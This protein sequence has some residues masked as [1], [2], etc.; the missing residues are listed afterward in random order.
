MSLG[1][2]K[3]VAEGFQHDGQVY[4]FR[5][6]R[7][8]RFANRRMCVRRSSH[9]NER[10]SSCRQLRGSNFGGCHVPSGR[11][12]RRAPHFSCSCVRPRFGGSYDNA[13]SR[14]TGSRWGRPCANHKR[15]PCRGVRAIRVGR[16]SVRWIPSESGARE[17]ADSP[18]RILLLWQGSPTRSDD[19]LDPTFLQIDA[20]DPAGLGFHHVVAS[21]RISDHPAE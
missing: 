17:P 15:P 10:A 2:I 8:H 7:Y 11:T 9:S 19:R 20:S 1:A 16:T 5:A 3:P 6:P 14:S 12:S 13:V 21:H 18:R 4:D